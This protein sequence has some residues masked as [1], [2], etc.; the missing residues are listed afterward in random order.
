MHIAKIQLSSHSSSCHIVTYAFIL[1]YVRDTMYTYSAHMH[2]QTRM[3]TDTQTRTRTYTHTIGMPRYSIFHVICH[4]ELC[5]DML[6]V[7]T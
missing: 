1:T 4:G 7:T 6:Y 5:H 2:V 3:H